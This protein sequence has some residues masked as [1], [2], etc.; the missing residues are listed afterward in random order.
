M[1]NQSNE[2]MSKI[3]LTHLL[4]RWDESKT[5]LHTTFI[6]MNPV[7]PVVMASFYQFVNVGNILSA[8]PHFGYKIH[9]APKCIFGTYCKSTNENPISVSLKSPISFSQHCLKTSFASDL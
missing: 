2:V 1:E 7:V 5:Q 9:L 8:G 4:K 3:V 6:D